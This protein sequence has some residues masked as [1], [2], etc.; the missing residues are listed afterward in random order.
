MKICQNCGGA[1]GEM[2]VTYGYAGPWCM[3]GDPKPNAPSPAPDYP[4]VKVWD[5]LKPGAIITMPPPEPPTTAL[6]F[7]CWLRGYFAA[8]GAH[9]F[10][11]GDWKRIAE[12]LAKVK[13]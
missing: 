3:C 4:N 7:V 13:P 11:Q 12:E 2:G 6:A 8:S 5:E 1:I 9:T 10:T